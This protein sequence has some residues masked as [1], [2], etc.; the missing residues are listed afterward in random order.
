MSPWASHKPGGYAGRAAT[1]VR[2]PCQ[3]TGCSGG[4]PRAGAG[5]LPPP[6]HAH[7]SE[8]REEW[9]GPARAGLLCAGGWLCV[10]GTP[11]GMAL[12]SQRPGER[13]LGRLRLGIVGG[14]GGVVL[15]GQNPRERL[16]GAGLVRWAGDGLGVAVLV[17]RV[18]LGGGRNHAERGQG[19]GGGEAAQCLHGAFLSLG[20]AIDGSLGSRRRPGIREIPLFVLAS[21]LRRP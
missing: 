7:R 10:G 5:P 11:V 20:C 15:P 8:Q 2:R 9:K 1:W 13:P 4:F 16:L 21:P 19:D 14:R 12:P 18:R 3:R 6:C 17:G